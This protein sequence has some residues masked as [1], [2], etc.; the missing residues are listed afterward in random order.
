MI[1]NCNESELFT[2]D[3][4]LLCAETTTGAV[5]QKAVQQESKWNAATRIPIYSL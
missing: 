4:I 5:A 1:V 2:K 3:E